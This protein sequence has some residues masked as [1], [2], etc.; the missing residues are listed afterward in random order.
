[1]SHSLKRKING[2]TGW[3]NGK[4]KDDTDYRLLGLVSVLQFSL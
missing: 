4:K 3:L 1:M 2:A